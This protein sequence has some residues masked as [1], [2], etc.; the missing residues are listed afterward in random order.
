MNEWED[1]HTLHFNRYVFDF[2]L[3]MS[4]SP[5]CDFV[6]VELYFVETSEEFVLLPVCR[7]IHQTL[8]NQIFDSV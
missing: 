4:H 7:Q 5:V 6:V 2:D 8:Y 3:H 1:F